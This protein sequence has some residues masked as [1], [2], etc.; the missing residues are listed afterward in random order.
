MRLVTI[1][2]SVDKQ[3]DHIAIYTGAVLT[4]RVDGGAQCRS[5]RGQAAFR[6]G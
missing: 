5:P 6:H 1:T 2:A 3:E 4:T